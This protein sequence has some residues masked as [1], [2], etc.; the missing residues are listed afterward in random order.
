ML[1]EEAPCDRLLKFKIGFSILNR[2][3]MVIF[4]ILPIQALDRVICV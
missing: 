3:A 4:K 2:E 1:E